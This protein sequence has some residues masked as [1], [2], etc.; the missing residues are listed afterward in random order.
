M[1]KELRFLIHPH[2]HVRWLS[3][4]QTGRY[5][6]EYIVAVSAGCNSHESTAAMTTAVHVAVQDELCACCEL[7]ISLFLEAQNVFQDY[8]RGPFA[9]SCRS[10]FVARDVMLLLLSYIFCSRVTYPCTSCRKSTFCANASIATP[11]RSTTQCPN[12]F[13]LKIYYF[14]Q[15]LP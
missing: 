6:T 15:T 2:F 12:V 13:Q 4:V 7:G 14:Q 3:I 8:T 11:S 1:K 10:I 5:G 9:D